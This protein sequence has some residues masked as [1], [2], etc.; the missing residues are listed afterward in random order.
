[1]A[2]RMVRVKSGAFKGR[3]GIPEDVREQYK[4]LYG[5]SREALF[6]APAECSVQ[7]AKA[8]LGEWEA[9][10]ENRID[11]LR[12][13]QRG[14][15]HD[16]TRRQ[17]AALAGEWYRW[18]VAQHAENPGTKEYWDVARSLVHDEIIEATREW[19]IDPAGMQGAG[20]EKNTP[21]LKPRIAQ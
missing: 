4:A 13:K 16:L 12:A 17:A 9:E 18:F 21:T 3:K 7:R 15:G 1:M 14:E 20:T 11:T 8:L 5:V 6:H 2:F 10:V 19:D